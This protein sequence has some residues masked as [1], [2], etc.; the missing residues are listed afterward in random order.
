MSSEQDDFLR[1]P[2]A[3]SPYIVESDQE[4]R[5]EVD[6]DGKRHTVDLREPRI[7]EDQLIDDIIETQTDANRSGSNIPIKGKWIALWL[8]NED[9]DYINNIWHNYQFFI[10]Y[11]EGVTSNIGG[12]GTYRRSP[13]TYDSMYRY[14]IMLEQAGLVERHRREVVP[15]EE[16]D[17]FVPEEF[18]VRTF[19]KVIT[20]VNFRESSNLVIKAWE[21][22]AEVVYGDEID[23]EDIE[24]VD[25]VIEPDEIDQVEEDEPEEEEVSE[26]IEETETSL[27]DPFDTVEELGIS[28]LNANISNFSRLD[29]LEDFILS[30]FDDALESGIEDAPVPTEGVGPEDYEVDLIAI[31]GEWAESNAN[32]GITPLKIVISIEQVGDIPGLQFIPATVS[33]TLG[34][35]LNNQN[36]IVEVFPQYSVLGTFEDDFDGYMQQ[37]AESA[38]EGDEY[39]DL[40]AKEFKEI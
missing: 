23:E 2:E 7:F 11:L 1:I 19:V 24:E 20:P 21:N 9:E 13:G 6:V 15:Q 30:Y 8:Q 4:L 10:K 25:E 29:G 31:Y 22:P 36:P 18:R 34:S 16:Y 27:G 26:M 38:Q 40:T 33:N 14:I 17:M 35:I 37:V 28:E 3:L 39:Y 5:V 12:I 32:A